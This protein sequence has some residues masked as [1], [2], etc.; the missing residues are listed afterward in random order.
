MFVLC[1]QP[2]DSGNSP[3]PEELL[4][5]RNAINPQMLVKGDCLTL[6]KWCHQDNGDIVSCGQES[7]YKRVGSKQQPFAFR[8]FLE[9]GGSNPAGNCCCMNSQHSTGSS[10]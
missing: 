3:T 5:A 9:L 2:R 7:T 8:L 10:D 1:G 4:F 6:L